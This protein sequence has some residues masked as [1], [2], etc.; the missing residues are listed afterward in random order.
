MSS[1]V[2]SDPARLAALRRR[3][4]TAIDQLHG[5]ASDD[6]A[7]AAAVAAARSIGH[8]LATGW[9]PVLD[10]LERRHLDDRVGSG[11]GEPGDGDI[12]VDSAGRRFVR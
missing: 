11:R 1:Y 9:L 12:R 3:V 6:P 5:L 7:A 4:I 10:H 2:G 8:E